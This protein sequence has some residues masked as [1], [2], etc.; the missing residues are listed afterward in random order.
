MILKLL[1]RN[2]TLFIL[3]PLYYNLFGGYLNKIKQK[4]EVKQYLDVA[5]H[6]CGLHAA[7]HVDSV[8]PDVK[9]GFASTNHSS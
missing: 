3:S 1:K 8:A 2:F 9:V 6:T 7:C 5:H 4:S